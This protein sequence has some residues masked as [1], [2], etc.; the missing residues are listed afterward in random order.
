[1][2]SL[3]KSI[4][5]DS[6][7]IEAAKASLSAILTLS[8]SKVDK[9][10][11]EYSRA[12]ASGNL[13]AANQAAENLTTSLEAYV[14]AEIDANNTLKSMA[15]DRYNAEK[16]AL[17]N[18]KSVIEDIVN[19]LKDIKFDDK[20]S[21]LKPVDRL[22]EAAMGF[23]ALR[24]KVF[25]GASNGNLTPEAL[26]S[27]QEDSKRLLDLGRDVYASGDKYTELYNSVT[28]AMLLAQTKTEAEVLKFESTTK[29][30]QEMALS[31][32]KDTRDIQVDS[33]SQL[34]ILAKSSAID[35]AVA[36]D[37]VNALK[38]NAGM[39]DAVTL[40]DY[41]KKLFS[42]AQG[43][44]TIFTQPEVG[45]TDF[46][47]IGTYDET[48]KATQEANTAKLNQVLDTLTTVL[49]NLPVNVKSA[50]QSTTASTTNRN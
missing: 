13:L 48:N 7:S 25:L 8:A 35:N 9:A 19:F 47:G 5:D 26:K 4:I 2:I 3:T 15:E 16:S 12:K 42:D 49:Q 27:L 40:S 6:G 22:T 44:G 34:K 39:S 1:M 31:Y 50:I 21:I 10:R 30:Y 24:A 14:N 43:G 28:S 45:Y 32:A 29:M 23:D 38:Y 18:L 36:I 46:N 11:E 37:M 20:L 41:Y 17:D 33:L